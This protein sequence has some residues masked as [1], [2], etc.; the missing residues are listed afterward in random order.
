M[1]ANAMDKQPTLEELLNGRHSCRGFLPEPVPRETIAHI[2]R[3]AQ[4]TPSWC[5]TQPWQIAITSGHAT[6]RFRDVMLAATQQPTSPD[7]AWPAYQGVYQERRRECGFALYE[8]VGVTRGDRAASAQ[9]ALENFRLFGAPHVAMVTTDA[10]LGVYGAIDC[11]AWVGNFMLAARSVGV[12]TVPQAA[13]SSWPDVV[14]E[15]FGL[16]AERLVVCGVS[17]GFEDPA[18][19]ANQFRTTRATLDAVVQW[20]D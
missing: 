8:S 10:T 3:I 14:R 13:L 4:R 9:Q 15:H 1:T 6:D 20:C 2:L 18:H 7:F 11:G 16:P 17:F 5:N 12:A 19:P